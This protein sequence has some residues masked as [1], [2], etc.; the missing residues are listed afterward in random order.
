MVTGEIEVAL[1]FGLATVGPAIVGAM[2]VGDVFVASTFMLVLAVTLV[3]GNI[4]AD[5]ALILL[6]PRLRQ[7]QR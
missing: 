1:V 5:L 6:D 7:A 4:L 3:V 2:A